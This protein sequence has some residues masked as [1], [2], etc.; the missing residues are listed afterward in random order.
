MRSRERITQKGWKS[1][2]PVTFK[3][4]LF[5]KSTGVTIFLRNSMKQGS[6]E[7]DNHSSSQNISRLS[8]KQGPKSLK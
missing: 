1:K 5:E 7:V 3:A 4:C 2:L 8:G 6:G